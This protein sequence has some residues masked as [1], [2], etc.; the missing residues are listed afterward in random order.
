MNDEDGDNLNC[1]RLFDPLCQKV[2][3]D[4]RRPI[5]GREEPTEIEDR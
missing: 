3:P 2:D 4:N 5:G 1:L